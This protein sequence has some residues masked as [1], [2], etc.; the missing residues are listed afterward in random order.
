MG[1]EPI[2]RW[3][4]IH[5]SCPCRALNYGRRTT[6][7]TSKLAHNATSCWKFSVWFVVGIALGYGLDD[8]D[9]RV[10]FPAWAG[11]FSLHR[12]RNGCGA[13][14][15]SYPMGTRDS[16][17]V[18]RPGRE[19]D[20]SPPFSAKVKMRG[21]IS[22]LPQYAFMAWCSVKKDTVTT[23]PFLLSVN[24]MTSPPTCA[25][26]F[27]C[28]IIIKKFKEFQPLCKI[29][30]E[31]EWNYWKQIR[32][33]KFCLNKTCSKIHTGKYFCPAYPIQ[34]C[35]QQSDALFPLVSSFAFRIHC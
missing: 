26:A 29:R 33:I 16:P 19:A 31:K 12:V 21:A 34:T 7:S 9:S 17:W 27:K 14:P 10:R 4:W 8:R 28:Y 22:P 5:K 13:H 20:R 23:L 11:N 24:L 3:W 18:K 32:L 25:W 35:L 15:A 6:L 2:C 30:Y 1:S